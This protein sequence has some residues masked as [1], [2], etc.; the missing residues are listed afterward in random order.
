VGSHVGVAGAVAL[1]WILFNAGAQA[2]GELGWP[3][4]DIHLGR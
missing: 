3:V 4:S 2:G 1:L